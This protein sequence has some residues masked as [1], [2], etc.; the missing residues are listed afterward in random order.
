[1]AAGYYKI[2]V[3]HLSGT[4]PANGA[5]ITV[6]FSR[7]GNQGTQGTTGATGAQGTTGTTGA[8]GTTGTTGA[9]GSAGLNLNRTITTYTATANQTSFS[10]TYTVPFIEVYLNG[11][12]LSSA[13]Y[14]AT[15]GTSVVL[16]DGA[17]ANDIIDLIAFNGG[18]LGAQG[19][20]G[21]QGTQGT[22]GIQGILGTQGSTGTS[23]VTVSDD[24]TTNA[25]RYILFEDATSGGVTST[26]ISSTKLTFNPSTGRLT[27]TAVFDSSG[28]LRTLP[29]NAVT[30]Y[31][32]VASDTGKHISVSTGGV[33]VPFNIFSTG[34][35]VTIYNN[36][37]SNQTI[38][39]ASS[40]TLRQS[41]TANTGNR[42]L[43]QYGV[44]TVLCVSGGSSS[45]FVISGSGLT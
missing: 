29:Q 42:T 27:S 10:V 3:T 7:T 13:E 45:V 1:M 8:Q 20:Q 25:T 22:Q 38:T 17:S 9:Q 4:L 18:V 14:T 21:V 35:V 44:A 16:V 41:G 24:T 26:N 11:I 12:R 36:S 32:L 23:S 5:T 6:R 28:N 2:P 30:S 34:D 33:T 40:V 15:N 43:A 37:G 31:T 19:I 39:Q